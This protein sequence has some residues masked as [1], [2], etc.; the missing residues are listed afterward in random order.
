VI[1]GLL[2]AVTVLRWFFDRA[3]EAVAL[4]YVVPI[5][6]AALRFGRKGGAAVA[7]C[8][9]IAF[10]VLETVRA[11][12]DLDLTGW[13]GPVLVMA[14]VGGLV[15]HLS[16]LAGTR[17]AERKLEAQRVEELRDAQRIAEAASDSIVQQVA[18]ARWLLEAG[19]SQEALAA[20]DDAVTEGI[21]HVRR[22]SSAPREAD[23]E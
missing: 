20:L 15:G 11:R 8:G 9:V 22:M 6:L 5:T 18:A 4:L 12:G 2:G 14:I 13:V 23:L 17:E 16:E 10:V 19:Q 7:G 21:E 1:A 3:G